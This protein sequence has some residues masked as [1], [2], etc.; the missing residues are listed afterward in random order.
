VKVLEESHAAFAEAARTGVLDARFNPARLGLHA[1]RQL[2]KM[3][4]K[5]TLTSN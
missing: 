1:V 3:P 4:V 5:F 2:S